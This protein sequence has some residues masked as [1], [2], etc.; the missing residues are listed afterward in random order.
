MVKLPA[1]N[2]SGNENF[3]Q[4]TNTNRDQTELIGTEPTYIP[5]TSWKSRQES[6][7]M[8]FEEEFILYNISE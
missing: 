2:L 6:N 1:N 3:F 7:M 5:Y 4:K 8:Y